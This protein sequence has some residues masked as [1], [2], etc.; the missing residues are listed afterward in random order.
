MNLVQ[1]VHQKLRT[2]NSGHQY[3]P[4]P[5]TSTDVLEQN[6]ASGDSRDPWYV[7]LRR[8]AAS[9]W[10]GFFKHQ[11]APD[12]GPRS[13]QHDTAWLDGLRGLAAFVVYIEH[14]SLPYQSGMLVAYGS[15][16]AQSTWQLPMIR[17]LYSGTP[18]VSIFFVVSGSA[19]SLKALR[20]AN[21]GQPEAAYA[22][23]SSSIFRRGIRLFAPTTIATFLILLL[24]QMGLY[25]HPYPILEIHGRRHM[26]LDRPPHLSSFWAQLVDWGRYLF[27]KLYYPELWMGPLTGSTSSIYASQLWTIPIE[28]YASMALYVCLA[29]LVG[30]C[31]LVRRLTL[32]GMAAFS[33][34]I[35]R[36]DLMLFFTG[37][38]IADRI[39]EQRRTELNDEIA[40]EK[41]SDEEDDT[42]HGFRKVLQMATSTT[43]TAMALLLLSY[44][45]H[46]AWTNPLYHILAAIDDDCRVWQSCG[47][48]LLALTCSHS[49]LLQR[50][51]SSSVIRWLGHISY[52]LY[53]VHI[54]ILVSYGWA[55]VPFAVNRGGRRI[56]DSL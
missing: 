14:F 24:T 48:V 27:A 6:N 16:G 39:T 13:S 54:P 46:E 44:P 17:L 22:S 33:L 42:D 34:V 9:G 31:R 47:A 5:T 15:P 56:W 11:N 4:L 38:L 51:L 55:L 40:D 45:D 7:V 29:G 36:W 1:V 35:L 12:S 32:G 50:L 41:W 20:F 43:L 19:L 23:L 28:F 26:V 37:A 30:T 10:S 21:S 3:I 25:E 8:N 49:S 2:A 18:M 52:G 53:I